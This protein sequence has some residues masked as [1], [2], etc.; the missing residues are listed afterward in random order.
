MGCH[1]WAYRKITDKESL[2][3]LIRNVKDNALWLH[4]HYTRE[5]FEEDNKKYLEESIE[6]YYYYVKKG[7]IIHDVS[8]VT[9]FL[10][11]GTWVLI[12]D[13]TY[14]DYCKDV[15]N[16]VRMCDQALAALQTVEEL[17]KFIID[18]IRCYNFDITDDIH[19]Q[20]RIFEDHIYMG[21]TELLSEVFKGKK[22]FRVFGYPCDQDYLFYNTLP[23]GIHNNGWTNA[24]DLISFLEWYKNTKNGQNH[25]PL[26]GDE[27]IDYGEELYDG[28]RDF[29]KDYK[30]DELLIDFG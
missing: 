25:K 9:Y 22:F 5:E 1:T 2:Q 20:K 17:E 21:S 13:F 4:A 23:E 27:Y 8:N 10:S 12:E 16:T 7:E 15:A 26:L 28:I 14:D 6:E 24:E 18:H 30:D 11:D 19:Y 3:Q 29:F